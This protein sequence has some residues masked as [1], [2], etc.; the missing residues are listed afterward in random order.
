MGPIFQHTLWTSNYFETSSNYSYQIWG[1]RGLVV[2][3]AAPKSSYAAPDLWSLANPGSRRTQATF[4]A[5]VATT[6]K[7][8][9]CC[10]ALGHGP[11]GLRRSVVIDL[12]KLLVT[13]YR[14]TCRNDRYTFSN[15]TW[16]WYSTNTD[17]EYVQC[18]TEVLLNGIDYYAKSVTMLPTKKC[19]WISLLQCKTEVLLSWSIREIAYQDNYLCMIRIISTIYFA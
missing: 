17:F 19:S 9:C 15:W 11:G 16:I 12:A 2:R 5:T 7:P 13:F 18:K 6:M 14:H 4:S 3:I 1:G 10:C 8:A